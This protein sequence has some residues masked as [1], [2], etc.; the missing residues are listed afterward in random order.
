MLLFKSR[1]P[2]FGGHVSFPETFGKNGAPAR[3]IKPTEDIVRIQMDFDEGALPRDLLERAVD[4][5]LALANGLRCFYA[6]GFVERGYAKYRGGLMVVPRKTSLYP[7]PL[8]REWMGIPPLPF[9]LNWFGRPYREL[10]MD[11]ARQLAPLVKV[12]KDGVLVRLGEKPAGLPQL[13]N[14]KLSLNLPPELLAIRVEPGLGKGVI[15]AVERG[16][17]WVFPA[18]RTQR[19]QLIPKLDD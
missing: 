6:H 9:W 15:A 18:Y 10:V 4:L 8:G 17:A 11:S 14:A 5:F 3:P 7:A 2:C 1:N 13:E 16:D 19:A 12:K